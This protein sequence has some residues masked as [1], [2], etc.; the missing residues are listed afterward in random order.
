MILPTKHLSV[1]DS[2]LGKGASILRT[3]SKPQSVSRLWEKNKK[4]IGSYELF[5]ITLAFLYSIDAIEFNEGLIM[6]NVS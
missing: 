1:D 6:R 5:S 2:I 3:L 4:T